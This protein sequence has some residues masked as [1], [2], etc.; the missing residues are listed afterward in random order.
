MLPQPSDSALP[1]RGSRFGTPVRVLALVVVIA[2]IILTVV[3]L[4]VRVTRTEPP[5]PPTTQPGIV[6]MSG[7]ELGSGNL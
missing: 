7:L 5:G 4:V 2:L 1:E 3:P 6:A